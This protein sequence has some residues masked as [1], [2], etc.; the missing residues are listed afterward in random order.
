MLSQRKSEIKLRTAETHVFRVGFL[1]L[2]QFTLSEFANASSV[3][4][5][6]NLLGSRRLYE[7]SVLTLDGDSVFSN[8]GIELKSDGDLERSTDYNFFVVC[9]GNSIE[10]LI[11]SKLSNTLRQ[12]ASLNI[13]LGAISSGTYALASA[14]VLEDYRCTVHWNYHHSLSERYPQLLLTTSPLVIDRDRYTCAGGVSSL[15]LMMNLVSSMHGQ[16]LVQRISEYLVYDR[17][18]TEDDLQRQPLSYLLGTSHPKLVEAATLMEANLEE[19][20]TLDEIASYLELSRRQLERLF[21]NHVQCSPS[22]YYLELRLRKARMLLLQSSI[23]VRDIAVSCGF[24]SGPHFSKRYK[25]LFG[26]P[27][28]VERLHR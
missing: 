5:T 18:R 23:P 8:D 3:L 25:Q 24:T 22:Q 4:C 27:P 13:P 20:L 15:D 12:L 21:L 9:S 2:P 14:G 26:R 16:K 11:N 17:V 1:V 7:W 19:L 10:N 6:A 28:R